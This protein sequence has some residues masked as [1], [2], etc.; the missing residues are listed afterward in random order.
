MS[1]AYA[2]WMMLPS[3][4]GALVPTKVD[5]GPRL[6]WTRQVRIR[7]SASGL[8]EFVTG[9]SFT[10]IALMLILH[11][12]SIR[13]IVPNSRQDYRIIWVVGTKEL[14]LLHR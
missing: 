4:E 12:N 14:Q 6:E 2:D 9:R 3:C 10:P 11:I 1:L 5:P 7:I 13:L 8:E